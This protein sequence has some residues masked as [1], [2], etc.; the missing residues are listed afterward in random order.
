MALH[1]DHAVIAVA[2]LDLAMREYEELG[3]TVIRGGVHA[4]RA[5]HNALIVFPDETYLELLAHTGQRPLPATIDFSV[6]LAHGAGAVGYALRTDDLA[7]DAARI[8]QYGFKVSQIF[9]GERR[10]LD[11]TLVQWRLAL[12]DEWF[13]PFLIED[14]TPRAYRIPTD[15]AVV[16]HMNGAEWVGDV[17][18]PVAAQIADF[19]AQTE[20]WMQI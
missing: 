8:E 5:T 2:D 9:P 15:P 19:L 3:F 6:L 14:V 13:A 10:R 12:V 17:A 20:Q 1:F 7:G 11:G 16:T 4:N 18:V